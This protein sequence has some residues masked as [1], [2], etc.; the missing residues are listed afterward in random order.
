MSVKDGDAQRRN[1]ALYE[2]SAALSRA[3]STQ[4]RRDS[5]TSEWR[6]T[7]RSTSLPKPSFCCRSWWIGA[8]T[9]ASPWSLLWK[10]REIPLQEGDNV[11]GRDPD[12]MISLDDPSVSRQHARIRVA[13]QKA[14]LED[15]SGRPRR[16]QSQ[17]SRT[18]KSPA[19]GGGEWTRR[20][21]LI[22]KS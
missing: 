19:V 3:L 17:A 9:P 15:P 6:T 16:S 12:S 14:T 1:R 11:L 18:A 4:C 21:S 13:Q 8:R 20:E 10:G 7:R 2:A 5:C 22:T